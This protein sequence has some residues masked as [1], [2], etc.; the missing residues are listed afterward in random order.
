MVQVRSVRQI[1][2]DEKDLQEIVQ[3][4]GKVMDCDGLYDG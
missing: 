2:Q 3:L 4:V 1:L